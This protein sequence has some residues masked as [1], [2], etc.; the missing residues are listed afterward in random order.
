MVL[1]LYLI[2][3]AKR[4]RIN[5]EIS[6]WNPRIMCI[7]KSDWSLENILTPRIAPRLGI[8]Q[9]QTVWKFGF[10]SMSLGLVKDPNSHTI[11]V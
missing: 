7:S 10:G 8:H 4:A 9:T 3:I 6:D 1:E 11:W 5:A 2:H